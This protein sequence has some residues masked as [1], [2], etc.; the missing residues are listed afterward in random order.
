MLCCESVCQVSL[1]MFTY[2]MVESTNV[3]YQDVFKGIYNV[4]LD[5]C[6]VTLHHVRIAYAHSEHVSLV[7]LVLTDINEPEH[8]RVGS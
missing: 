3:G 6:P 8:K 4:S 7:L 2:S 1:Y 5:V